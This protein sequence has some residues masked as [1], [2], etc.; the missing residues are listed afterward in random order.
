MFARMMSAPELEAYLH[1]HIPISHAMGMTVVAVAEDAVVLRARLEPNLN[2]RSTAFGGS[3]A[4]LAVLAGWSLLRIGL[5]GREPL[6]QIVIQRSTMEYR[7][8]IAAGFEATCLRPADTHWQRFLAALARRGRA[9]ID[10]DVDVS[11]AGEPAA[12][13]HAS[14][15]ALGQE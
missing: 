10:L 9:R 11:V 7:A 15:V 6:P 1:R 14:F 2:H 4:S 5:D 12:Q 8:P 3:V 13:L